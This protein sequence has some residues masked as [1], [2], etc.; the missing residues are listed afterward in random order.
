[1]P[2]VVVDLGNTIV[3]VRP[4][5]VL[6][7]SGNLALAA[8]LYD[9]P[10]DPPGWLV[11]RL[12]MALKGRQYEALVGLSLIEAAM[13]IATLYGGIVLVVNYNPPTPAGRLMPL[14]GLGLGDP[15]TPRVE[16]DE[17]ILDA[18]ASIFW[19]R[20]ASGCSISPT[21]VAW[22]YPGDI[23]VAPAGYR[24]RPVKH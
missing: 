19:N 6:G 22:R 24:S 3:E 2:P 10:W 1:M 11:E 12:T 16:S 18:W 14:G 7:A 9:A 13:L 21:N 23:Q 8:S 4:S 20:E 15:C 17:A 5:I